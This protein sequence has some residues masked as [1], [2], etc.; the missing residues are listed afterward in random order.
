MVT[1]VMQ[2]RGRGACR[3]RRAGGTGEN[4]D[5]IDPTTAAE[6]IRAIGVR[7]SADAFSLVVMRTAEA[8][9]EICELLPAVM[10][11]VGVKTGDSRPNASTLPP[12]RMHSSATISTPPAFVTA[13]ITSEQTPS[14][15]A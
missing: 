13:T 4:G 14:P 2:K 8:P 1:H 6:W 15:W 12:R 3:C 5:G 7:P 9:S 11:P 10:H